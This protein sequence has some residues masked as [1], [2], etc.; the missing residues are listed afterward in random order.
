[1]KAVQTILGLKSEF[2]SWFDALEHMYQRAMSID[3]DIAI[4]GCGA[5]AF[6]LACKLKKSGRSAITTC[7]PT[8]VLFGIKGDRWKDNQRVLKL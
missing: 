2:P 3:F 5:Y 1:M 6:P 7:G 8:Q 4:I